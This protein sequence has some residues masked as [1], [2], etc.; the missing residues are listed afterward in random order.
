MVI[1]TY[2]FVFKILGPPKAS[3]P[4][5]LEVRTFDEAGRTLIMGHRHELSACYVAALSANPD[6]RGRI[7]SLFALDAFGN[8]KTISVTSSTFGDSR[9]GGLMSRAWCSRL[10]V[11]RRVRMAMQS[12][13]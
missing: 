4:A 3:K 5:P 2:P 9:D 6:V 8:V 11:Q 7:G 12:P 10:A 13:L 1:V